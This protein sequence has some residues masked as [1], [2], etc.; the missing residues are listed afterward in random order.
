MRGGVTVLLLWCSSVAPPTPAFA[1][2]FLPRKGSVHSD[3]WL[4]QAHRVVP[5][6]AGMTPW[7]G[8]RLFSTRYGQSEQSPRGERVFRL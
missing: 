7:K 1:A 5:A 2:A 6:F 8:M 3:A 4:R